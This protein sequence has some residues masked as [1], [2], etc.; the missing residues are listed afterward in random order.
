MSLNSTCKM[1]F[2]VL[3]SLDRAERS[4]EP[5][6][7]KCAKVYAAKG[8]TVSFQVVV[9]APGDCVLKIEDMI[10]SDFN[11]QG[12][13]RIASRDISI[14][15]EHYIEVK[16]PSPRKGGAVEPLGLQW[17]PDALIPF[18]DPT[19]GE[20]PLS[21]A[22]YK[23]IPYK[24]EA[25][26]NQPFWI[27]IN[28]PLGTNAGEYEGTYSIHTDMGVCRGD[29][30]LRVWNFEVPVKS[31]LY[32][33]FL[34]WGGGKY[35]GDIDYPTD[36]DVQKE[37]LRN[38][39]C[40]TGDV[41]PDEERRL[42]DNM[43]LNCLSLGYNSGASYGNPQMEKPPLPEVVK[44]DVERH[45]P[46]LLLYDFSADEI[47]GHPELYDSVKEWARSLHEAG[48]ENLVTMTPVPELFDDG[49]GTGR[50]AV[51]IWCVLSVY[52]EAGVNIINEALSKGDS[53]WTY[54]AL[55]QD[56]YSPKWELDFAPVS[57]RVHTGFINQSIGSNGILYWSVNY[58][59]ADPWSD[60]DWHAGCLF[61]N[62][63]DL[64]GT[65]HFPGEGQLVYP[66]SQAGCRGVVP[67]MRL[68]FIRD[69]VYDYD[70]IELLKEKGYGEWALQTARSIGADFRHW[71]KDAA[72]LEAI[73]IMLAGK[74][75][76]LAG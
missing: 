72:R 51:D 48:V 65:D 13:A 43:G 37:L 45:Q 15:R 50:S 6:S 29:I 4:S 9:R 2:W 30:R 47:D 25:G 71:T 40:P 76:S 34:V 16:H 39:L 57:Y 59:T 27:D 20:K 5:G 46:D 64:A 67:S 44:T 75:E 8:E 11:G 55:V 31:K 10:V 26:L 28:I 38:R 7:T 54:T 68:K 17:Y 36:P 12:D 49:S 62:I 24:L 74:I 18:V 42:I 41:D 69:G 70:Y 66:G 23:A 1:D 21:S 32:S 63:E 56:D 53:L 14:F 33:S 61:D 58:W 35:K 73:R 19:T 52:H 3:G 22:V 60:Q